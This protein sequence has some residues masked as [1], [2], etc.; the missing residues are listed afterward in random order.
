MLHEL[1]ARFPLLGA[2]YWL[3][4]EF[5]NIIQDNSLAMDDCRN[6]TETNMHN[7]T[8][9]TPHDMKSMSMRYYNKHITKWVE[10]CR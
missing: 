3:G 9:M 7:L 5:I 1:F 8:I 6:D 4:T 10:I 2:L